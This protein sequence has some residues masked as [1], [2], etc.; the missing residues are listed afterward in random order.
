MK[1]LLRFGIVLL[2]LGIVDLMWTLWCVHRA[3]RNG[4][5][6]VGGGSVPLGIIAVGLVMLVVALIFASAEVRLCGGGGSGWGGWI[7][8]PVGSRVRRLPR[9]CCRRR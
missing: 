6:A 2:I 5:G 1:T 9:R 7:W 8:L 3:T 4:V